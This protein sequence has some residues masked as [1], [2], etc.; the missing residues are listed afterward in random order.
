MGWLGAVLMWV[1][2]AVWGH[3][4]RKTGITGPAL[5]LVCGL[6]VVG[7]LLTLLDFRQSTLPL[8][9]GALGSVLLATAL[10]LRE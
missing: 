7:L 9:L 8:L 4:L 1:G 3:S 10:V 6:F 5:L 2:G